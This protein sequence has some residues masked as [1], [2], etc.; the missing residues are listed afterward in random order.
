MALGSCGRHLFK[1]RTSWF[2]RKIPCVQLSSPLKRPIGFQTRA[3]NIREASWRCLDSMFLCVNSWM[4]MLRLRCFFL[5]FLLVQPH[6]FCL[7]YVLRRCMLT[8]DPSPCCDSVFRF[9]ACEVLGSMTTLQRKFWGIR[10]TFDRKHCSTTASGSSS[11]Q[12]S[13]F[14]HTKEARNFCVT[15]MIEASQLRN[16]VGRLGVVDRGKTAMLRSRARLRLPGSSVSGPG[17]TSSR[18]FSSMRIHPLWQVRI[19]NEG[20]G[21]AIAFA[22]W[23]VWHVWHVFH[24]WWFSE[25]LSH[26]AA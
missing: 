23:H 4:Q 5:V 21:L 13:V 17:S 8:S 15:S 12:H 6:T 1:Y 20:K 16:A 18:R 11:V 14:L 10:E 19:F 26:V 3:F 7:L 24:R 2:L 22:D 25:N 9:C